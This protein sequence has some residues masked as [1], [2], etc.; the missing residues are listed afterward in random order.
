[1][2]PVR[3][4]RYHADTAPC[5]TDFDVVQLADDMLPPT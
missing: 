3:E 5:G 4:M 1:M 2:I